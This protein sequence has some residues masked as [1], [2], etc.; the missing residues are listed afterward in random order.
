MRSEFTRLLCMVAAG[1]LALDVQA[2]EGSITLPYTNSFEIS[3]HPGYYVGYPM[4][5]QPGWGMGY[6]MTGATA[7]V[8]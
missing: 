8:A 3:E 1:L 2:A 7:V 6:G 5:N 4:G